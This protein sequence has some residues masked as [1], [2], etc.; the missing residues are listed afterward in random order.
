MDINETTMRCEHLMLNKARRA[1]PAMFAFCVQ[2]GG[3]I[4]QSVA[5]GGR[6]D[7]W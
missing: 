1:T 5:A 3:D 4:P 7:R 2:I 6:G